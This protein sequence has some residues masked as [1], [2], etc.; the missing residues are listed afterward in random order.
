[1]AKNK[2]VEEVPMVTSIEL[3]AIKRDR[4]HM[5]SL[6]A[7][8]GALAI[9][10]HDRERDVIRRIEGGADVGGAAMVI[11]RRRQSISWLT[12]VADELGPDTVERIKN[13]WPV[14]FWK[15]LQIA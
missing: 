12:V 13:V 2:Q 4:E 14:T 6:R 11:V 7:E 5:A 1:M 9:D 8:L 10:V 15:E 3:A